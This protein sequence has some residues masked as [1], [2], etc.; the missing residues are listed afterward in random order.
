[1][2]NEISLILRRSYKLIMHGLDR[3]QILLN[4]PVIASTSFV[5]IST[6]PA[7]KTHIIADINKNG[8]V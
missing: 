4:D 8:E 3:S 5:N 2:N 6:K 7:N 1:M